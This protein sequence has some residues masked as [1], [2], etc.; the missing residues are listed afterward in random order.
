MSEKITPQ[1]IFEQN[2]DE[3]EKVYVPR[4]PELLDKFRS[5]AAKRIIQP[6]L[7]A[8]SE[9]FSLRLR[10]TEKADTHKFDATLKTSGTIV[11]A[12]KSR[13]EYTGKLTENRFAYYN[14]DE[15]PTVRKTRVSPLEKIDIDFFDDGEAWV[16]SEDP[17][18]WN[19]F[20]DHYSY[21]ADDFID[22]TGQVPDNELRAHALYRREHGGRDAF[23]PYRPFDTDIALE[24]I[25]PYATSR[26]QLSRHRLPV[27]RVFGRSGSGKSYHLAKLRKNLKEAGV[28]SHLVSTDDY[29][30]GMKQLIEQNKGRIPEN[31]DHME[32]YDIIR[33]RKDVHELL[34]GRPIRQYA[35][36]WQ[37]SEPKYQRTLE[38]PDNG[39]IFVEGIWARHE[40]FDFADVSLDVDT[41][42]AT[43]LGQ[44]IVRDAAERREFA[45]PERSM[46][47]YLEYA[48]PEYRG[49]S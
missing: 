42:L 26:V 17:E 2:Y 1:K 15:L 12:G 39:V 37:T 30:I 46:S 49:L 19:R 6:Y 43:S 4:I 41:P 35:F 36:D 20:L 22:L 7:S 14:T 45:E 10:N 32:A 3:T 13:D 8:P 11:E 33:A 5:Q 44:R 48:E 29:N 31:F 25:L 27:V 24:A 40:A 23:R 21:H 18:A 9:P 34:D 28:S 16:E 47:Y 38:S